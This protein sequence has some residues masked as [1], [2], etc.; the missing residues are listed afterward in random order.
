MKIHGRNA[1][2]PGAA[3]YQ[4]KAKRCEAI[5]PTIGAGLK[6]PHQCTFTAAAKFGRVNLC[7]RHI[8]KTLRDRGLK[9]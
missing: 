1:M 6:G 2:V 3:W 8:R 7:R 4:G 9:P 5:V